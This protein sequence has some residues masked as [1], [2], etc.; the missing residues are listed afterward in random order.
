MGNL[1]DKIDKISLDFDALETQYTTGNC[2]RLSTTMQELESELR[3]HIQEITKIEIKKI[4]EKL[5]SNTQLEQ[6]EIDYIKLWICGD[7][8]Y[9]VQM[10]NNLNDW[11]NELKRLVEAIKVMDVEQADFSVSSKL[12]AMLLDGI[13]VSGDIMFF[14]KQKERVK[15]FTESTL[16]IDAPERDLLI[17]LLEGKM[18][19]PTE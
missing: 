6:Q 13:R 7:A 1:K 8:D 11:I 19:S 9:Y 4:I 15:N 5:R 2:W 14:L 12:R 17:K 18:A 3:E 16:E 10:E